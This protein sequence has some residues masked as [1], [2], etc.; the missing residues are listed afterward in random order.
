MFLFKYNL[1]L[2]QVNVTNK[3]NLINYFTIFSIINKFFKFNFILFTLYYIFFLTYLENYIKQLI[4]SNNLIKLFILNENE[5]EI[6]SIDDLFFFIILFILVLFSF[7]FISIISIIFNTS[8]L[9]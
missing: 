8:F 6:G 9:L 1:G 2:L 3:N 5:K 7:V 4:V